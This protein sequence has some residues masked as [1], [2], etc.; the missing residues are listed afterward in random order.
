LERK[1][2]VQSVAS[3]D[4]STAARTEKKKVEHLVA[5]T[6]VLREKR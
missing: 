1:W 4:F 6:A 2:D 5:Q 3:R